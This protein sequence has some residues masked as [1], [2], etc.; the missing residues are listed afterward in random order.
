M[1]LDSVCGVSSIG[2]NDVRFRR[3]SVDDANNVA[4]LH[5][6]SWRRHYRGAY[7]DS[8]LDGDVLGDRKTVWSERL[9]E[10]GHSRTI[11]AEDDAGLIGFI[12]VIFD[13]D[14]RWGSL[15]DNLHVDS[16]RRRGGVGTAL[17]VRAGDA[18]RDQAAM[19]A[20]Y[21]W[22][23][24]QNTAAQNFYRARGGV[25]VEKVAV[26]PP[27]GVASRLIGSPV[28]IRVAWPELFIAM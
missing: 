24:D 14:P 4:A 13:D 19:P 18:I 5:A 7:S 25:F 11:L 17:L 23:L 21:L 28:G 6:D 15:I 3:A 1:A 27:G 22:V 2:G 8:F 16:S 20:A 26:P 12:H 9:A 10:P